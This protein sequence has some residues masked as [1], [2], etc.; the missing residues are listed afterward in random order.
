MA[1]HKHSPDAFADCP[2]CY[3][4][5]LRADRAPAIQAPGNVRTSQT[6]VSAPSPPIATDSVIAHRIVRHAID[7]TKRAR[8]LTRDPRIILGAFDS[9]QR[10]IG[11]PATAARSTATLS[12]RIEA[13]DSIDV[14]HALDR[15]VT[16]ALPRARMHVR[17]AGKRTGHAA[18]AIG[19]DPRGL[20]SADTMTGAREALHGK[21][22]ADLS[23]AFQARANATGAARKAATSQIRAIVA[24]WTGDHEI[25]AICR[26]NDWTINAIS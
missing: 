5:A 17:G 24:I 14:I 19:M 9:V 12:A 4:L 18:A 25:A 23:R 6:P 21:A 2:A 10:S 7:A 20:P 1:T 13:G 16:G 15:A 26:A 11:A 8:S 22:C 3:A